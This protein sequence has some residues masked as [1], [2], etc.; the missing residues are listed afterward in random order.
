MKT[1]S[2][3]TIVM[4]VALAASLA[5]AYAPVAYAANS[6]GQALTAGN[7][8]KKATAKKKTPKPK[9]VSAVKLSSKK[10]GKAAISWKTSKLKG[11][12]KQTYTVRYAYNKSM[13]NAKTKTVKTKSATLTKLKQGKK[14]Y[15]QVRTNARYGKKTLHSAWSGV[16]AVK[17][18]KAAVN[19]LF[20]AFRP[21]CRLDILGNTTKKTSANINAVSVKWDCDKVWSNGIFRVEYS[22][23][24][25]MKNAKAVFV[26]ADKWRDEVYS[27]AGMPLKNLTK[28][29]TLY[30]RI[31]QASPIS[32][33]AIG[34]M[35]AYLESPWSNTASIKIP[36]KWIKEQGHWEPV[37][38]TVVDQ[39]AYTTYTIVYYVS[40]PG[41]KTWSTTDRDAARQRHIQYG[42]NSWAENVPEYHS[43]VTHQ[44][45]TGQRWVVDEPGHWV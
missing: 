7:V 2:I 19:N 27:Y 12:K 34:D 6:G 45:Q 38:T 16:K 40:S 44:E 1:K 39:E 32:S 31:K 33:S 20:A 41:Q 9:K 22:Y 35:N 5:V 24:K 23:D 3:I 26:S 42:G 8:N 36:S 14:L 28:G 37:Y 43:A 25:S 17:V 13:K 29:K 4:C 30:V 18:K 21:Y 10:V 15:V 11:L